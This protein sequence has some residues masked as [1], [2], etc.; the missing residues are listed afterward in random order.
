M[1][2]SCY[3]GKGSGEGGGQEGAGGESGAAEWGTEEISFQL[4]SVDHAGTAACQPTAVDAGA[5]AYEGEKEEEGEEE[6]KEGGEEEEEEKR[7][8]RRRQ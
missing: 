3:H 6:G 8:E 7:E 2:P 4:L 1:Q 5:P